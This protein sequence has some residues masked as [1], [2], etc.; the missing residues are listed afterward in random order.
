MRVAVKQMDYEKANERVKE[1]NERTDRIEAYIK[2]QSNTLV[3]LEN[4]ATKLEKSR[5]CG[6]GLWYGARF[7]WQ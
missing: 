3:D 2:N 4:K 6:D 1:A 5:D 7:R